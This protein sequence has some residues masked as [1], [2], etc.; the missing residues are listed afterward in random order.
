MYPQNVD[1]FPEKLN[2]K[3]TGFYVVEEK[4]PMVD[5]FFEGDLAHDSINNGSVL[6]YTGSKLTGEQV[7]AYTL[8]LPGEEPWRRIIKVFSTAEFV[9]VTYETPGDIVEA[10]D[11]NV[12][13]NSIVNTQTELERHKADQACHIQNAEIDGGSFL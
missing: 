9:Y 7:L 8:S 10:A 6:V 13:Q 12:V 1:Q 11:I 4:I 2:K 3:Q 5:G